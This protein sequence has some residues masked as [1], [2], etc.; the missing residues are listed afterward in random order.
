MSSE[1]GFP[2]VSRS[3]RAPVPFPVGAGWLVPAGGETNATRPPR[4]RAI[5]R[6]RGKGRAQGGFDLGTGGSSLVPAL[7]LVGVLGFTM[8]RDGSRELGRTEVRGP[9]AD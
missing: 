8:R 4:A 5:P 6:L 2:V 7:V 3:L 1:I 9:D